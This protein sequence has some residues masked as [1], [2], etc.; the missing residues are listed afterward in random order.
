MVIIF[1]CFLFFILL[2]TFLSRVF[3]RKKVIVIDI[4]DIASDT[5]QDYMDGYFKSINMESYSLYCILP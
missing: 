1:I 3:F 5:D 4:V 2:V